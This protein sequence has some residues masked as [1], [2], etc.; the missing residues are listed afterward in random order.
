MGGLGW[1][2]LC[3]GEGRDVSLPSCR[4]L[5]GHRAVGR[6]F[7]GMCAAGCGAADESASCRRQSG[8]ECDE[9]QPYQGKEEGGAACGAEGRKGR[10]LMQVGCE[11]VSG[12]LG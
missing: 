7:G 8:G 6:G 12:E 3:A 10:A 1:G 4:K 5:G 11:A 2:S 9:P